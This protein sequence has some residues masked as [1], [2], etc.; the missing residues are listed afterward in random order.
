MGADVICTSTDLRKLYITLR[1]AKDNTY[2]EITCY[3]FGLDTVGHGAYYLHLKIDRHLESRRYQLY[4][5]P[6]LP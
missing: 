3:E 5:S 4:R 1:N 6:Q 2:L